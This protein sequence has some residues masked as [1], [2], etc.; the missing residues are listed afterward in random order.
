MTALHAAEKRF[1]PMSFRARRGIC[2]L[3]FKGAEA[4]IDLGASFGAMPAKRIDDSPGASWGKAFLR[5]Q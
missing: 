5:G 1:C 4:R 3:H 2:F